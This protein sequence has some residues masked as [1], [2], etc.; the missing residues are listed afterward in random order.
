MASD[1]GAHDARDAL[2]AVT[3]VPLVCPDA[4]PPDAP[5]AST[6]TGPMTC[7]GEVAVAGVTPYGRFVAANVVASLGSGDCPGLGI[8]FDDRIGGVSRD[9]EIVLSILMIPV[10]DVSTPFLGVFDAMG[11][12][13]SKQTSR[14]VHARVEL[15]GGEA[16]DPNDGGSSRQ[17]G[18]GYGLVVGRVDVDTGCGHVTGTFSVPI[19][20]SF[21]CQI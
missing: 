9:D 1:G 16:F 2:D 7:G 18:G 6:S 20:S 21:V 11:F 17:D 8:A 10:T 5:D 13:E 3:D 12:V 19:C 4:N 14:N 15:T